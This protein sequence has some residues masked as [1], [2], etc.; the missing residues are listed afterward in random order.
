[1][2]GNTNTIKDM[3]PQ[4]VYRK[5]KS[6]LLFSLARGLRP[7][8]FFIFSNF[9]SRPCSDWLAAHRRFTGRVPK[10]K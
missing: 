6:V 10:G 4:G 1:M 8:D 2:S 5:R 3:A 9:V 7:K